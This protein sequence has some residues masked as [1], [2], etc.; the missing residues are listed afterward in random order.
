MAGRGGTLAV[1]GRGAVVAG[2]GGAVVGHPSGPCGVVVV[3]RSRHHHSSL[4]R[5]GR[6]RGWCKQWL[7]L[8]LCARLCAHVIVMSQL[9]VAIA[10]VPQCHGASGWVG[11]PA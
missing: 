8:R 3:G 10:S 1:V 7:R 6:L 4:A 9:R 2:R 11:A 5:Q